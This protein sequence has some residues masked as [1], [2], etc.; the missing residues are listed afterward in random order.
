MDPARA[1][2]TALGAA[3]RRAYHYTDL[4]KGSCDVTR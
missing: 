1:S 3:Y 4:R 2:M